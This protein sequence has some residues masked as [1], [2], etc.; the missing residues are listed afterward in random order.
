MN[1]VT[2]LMEPA[3]VLRQSI[4]KVTPHHGISSTANKHNPIQRTLYLC[5]QEM[6]RADSGKEA[7]EEKGIKQ[8][9]YLEKI[10][11]KYMY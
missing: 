4:D 10:T 8:P 3:A 5:F 9:H 7:K 1:E 2:L 6:C 11:K